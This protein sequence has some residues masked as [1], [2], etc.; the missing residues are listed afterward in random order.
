MSKILDLVEFVSRFDI[1]ILDF[2]GVIKDS[3][4][5]KLEAFL[6]LFPEADNIQREFIRVHH[7]QNGGVN[8]SVKIREYY[9][10]IEGSLPSDEILAEL[11]ERF[12]KYAIEKVVTAASFLEVG[13]LLMLGKQEFYLATATPRFEIQEIMERIGIYKRFSGVYGYP[14]RKAEA[15]SNI[16]N[17]STAANKNVVFVGDSM[18]DYEAAKQN[19]VSFVLCRNRFNRQISEERFHW[20]EGNV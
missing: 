11:C 7:L 9:R 14:T 18:Q 16:V 4:G 5:C 8:R 20:Y 12:S 2:D 10:E 13:K 17:G 15:I 19:Q 6:C 1:I 3:V